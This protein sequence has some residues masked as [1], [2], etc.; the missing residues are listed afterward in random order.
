MFNQKKITFK[1]KKKMVQIEI[2]HLKYFLCFFVFFFTFQTSL[3]LSNRRQQIPLYHQ[4]IYNWLQ[5]CLKFFIRKKVQQETRRKRQMLLRTKRKRQILYVLRMVLFIIF[6][7][8]SINAPLCKVFFSLSKNVKCKNW[9]RK[10][11]NEIVQKM[12]T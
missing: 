2:I 5:Q 3:F 6:T 8:F 4:N 7:V 10:N 9:Y 11:E 12:Y 1:F